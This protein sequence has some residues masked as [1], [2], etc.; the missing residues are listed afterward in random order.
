MIADVEALRSESFEQVGAVID[1]DGEVILDR[2]Q[3]CAADEQPNARRLHHDSLRDHLPDLLRGLAASLA[4]A[5]E[6]S[7][8]A[9]RPPAV[10][11]GKERW[12]DGWSLDEVVRDYQILRRVL[13]EH[14]DAGLG[15]PL[16]LRENLAVGMA[17]DEAIADSVGRYVRHREVDVRRQ[18]QSEADRLRRYAADL[19][20]A[21]RHKD[22]FLAVLG[23]E[24][25]NPLAPVRNAVQLLRQ[26]PDAETAA[27][28]GEMMDRQLRHLTRLVDDLLDT[29]RLARGKLELRRDRLDLVQLVRATAEDR[30][31]LLEEAGRELVLQLASAPV[32]VRGDADRLAQVLDNL[33]DNAQ[34]FTDRGGRISVSLTADAGRA[35]LTVADTGVGIPPTALPT[36]FQW[37]RQAQVDPERE[38]GGL[39]L[40]LALVKGLVELHGGNVSAASDGPG[41]GATITIVLPTNGGGEHGVPA[42][43]KVLVIEDNRDGADSLAVLL[44]LFGYDARVAYSG[45]E[46]VSAAKADPPDIILC[47][48]G[49]P[50]MDG[51]AVA[52]AL[53]ADAA[54]AD[55]QLVAIS[56]HGMEA[57]RQRCAEAGFVRHV[58]KPVEPEEV[59]NLLAGLTKSR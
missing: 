49:L 20:A 15:R 28:A 57:E 44:R 42:T 30:R 21:E 33:L 55:I 4:S 56:G 37:Y 25:R 38:N 43:A 22:E 35:T 2:W 12:E 32:L 58:L 52:A 13:L 3:R 39:G 51:Y 46:G 6:G 8:D 29:S 47:D 53:K 23:H 10:R 31:R 26:K 45:Q 48:L 9:H 54:T 18:E 27:W 7:G 19:A 34:K 11:H 14:L 1:R 36:V 24:L 16:S 40:G 59:R 41:H 5:G 50:G 17:L